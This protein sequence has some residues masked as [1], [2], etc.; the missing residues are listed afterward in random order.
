MSQHPPFEIWVRIGSFLSLEEL[1]QFSSCSWYF[2]Q[3]LQYVEKIPYEYSEKI[4]TLFPQL[5]RIVVKTPIKIPESCRELDLYFGVWSGSLSHLKL[6]S[7]RAGPLV[8]NSQ[9]EGQDFLEYLDCTGALRLFPQG[10]KLPNL[11]S[12]IPGVNSNFKG[13][14]FSKLTSLTSLD[15]SAN[16]EIDDKS[17]SSLTSLTC[18]I[19]NSFCPITD[20]TLFHQPNLTELRNLPQITSEGLSSCRNLKIFV[21]GDR[22]ESWVLSDLTSLTTLDFFSP[23]EGNALNNLTNLKHLSLSHPVP[24]EVLKR[25]TNLQSLNLLECHSDNLQ[26]LENHSKLT[27]LEIG[28][29]SNPEIFGLGNL[30]QLTA[31]NHHSCLSF[32]SDLSKLTKLKYLQFRLPPRHNFQ[33]KYL[34]PLTNLLYLQI[35]RFSLEEKDVSFLLKL[36]KLQNKNLLKEEISFPSVIPASTNRVFDSSKN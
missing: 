19:G 5:K 2:R 6:R 17:L 28:F 20:L 36:R 21:G 18:L 25:L 29:Q 30:T 4:G 33:I 35:F 24:S 3:L 10:W 13:N 16:E 1:V 14:C 11:K 23:I 22:V 26:A 15:L 8:T 31:L 27:H 7:L 9:L 32:S 34:Q 12:L